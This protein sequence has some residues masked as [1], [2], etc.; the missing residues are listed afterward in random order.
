[1]NRTINW[2]ATGG[3]YTLSDLTFDPVNLDYQAA[4]GTLISDTLTIG[5]HVDATS[6]L[7]F[8]FVNIPAEVTIT[9]SIGNLAPGDTLSLDLTI[10][11]NYM[12]DNF[13]HFF[14]DLET[15]DPDES[16][17]KLPVYVSIG[18]YQEFSMPVYDQWNLITVPNSMDWTAEDLGQAIDG[19]TVICKFNAETQ[20]FT[21]H[22]VGIPHNDFP[23]LDGCGYYVYTT[24][25]TTFTVTGAPITDVSIPLSPGWNMIGW[26]HDYDTT[27]ESLGD[28]IDGC[29]VIT[30]F[31]AQ[32]QQFTTHVVGILHNNYQITAGMGLFVYVTEPSIWYG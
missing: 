29:T 22:V 13:S 3:S 15:N 16:L 18:L 23:I 20:T 8:N 6:N 1:M 5:N 14:L 4:P 10:D 17:V 9:P 27:A 25:D 11:T 30:M 24:I 32:T 7:I 2:L 19:C 31:D 28:S 26:Y 12:T 21:T